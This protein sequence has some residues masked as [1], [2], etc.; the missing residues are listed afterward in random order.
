MCPGMTVNV[1]FSG[2]G[3]MAGGEASP[4]LPSLVSTEFCPRSDVGFMRVVEEASRA[5]PHSQ[6]TIG[7][8]EP[9]LRKSGQSPASFTKGSGWETPRSG[10]E[11]F[12]F[13]W[14]R[15]IKKTRDTQRPSSKMVPK[16][17]ESTSQPTVATP[18]RNTARWRGDG[19]LT[20]NKVDAV[21]RR[22]DY[23]EMV[24]DL[25]SRDPSPL[26]KILPIK[27]PSVVSLHGR[28][29]SGSRRHRSNS[30][31]KENS[32]TKFPH[33]NGN[34]EPSHCWPTLPIVKNIKKQDPATDF[35][36]V[37]KNLWSH[38]N[39]RRRPAESRRPIKPGTLKSPVLVRS[40]RSFIGKPND[41]K[42]L[43]QDITSVAEALFVE[44]EQ[45]SLNWDNGKSSSKQNDSGEKKQ[46]NLGKYLSIDIKHVSSSK[47][48]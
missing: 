15:N 25:T 44:T 32:K 41:E 19:F 28:A 35:Q 1:A 42:S 43:L 46:E 47:H 39:S 22:G 33:I 34:T 45:M 7:N 5:S 20:P 26:T 29:P 14:S 4:G 18:R 36:Y 27:G 48:I 40:P 2:S 13:D 23:N 6:L 37:T 12:A 9:F 30:L 10:K 31:T 16:S 24:V 38:G 11:S 8:M 3:R 21:A 17:E